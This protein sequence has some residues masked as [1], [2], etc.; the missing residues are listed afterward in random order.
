MLE[1]RVIDELFE[2]TKEIF[3]S[4]LFGVVLY[5]DPQAIEIFVISN[6]E[7]KNQKTK[8]KKLK[9][10]L[11]TKYSVELN[12]FYFSQADNFFKFISSISFKKRKESLIKRL[13]VIYST[14]RFSQYL[15]QSIYSRIKNP[16]LNL[17]SYKL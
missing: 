8:L 6:E 17:D 12:L 16:S 9:K 2:K 3:Q 14:S 11:Q 15:I 1:K 5:E 7:N 4:N 13:G 10:T